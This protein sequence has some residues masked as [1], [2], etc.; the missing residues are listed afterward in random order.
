MGIEFF[1]AIFE[2]SLILTEKF[3]FLSIDFFGKIFVSSSNV[4]EVIREFL[5]FLFLIFLRKDFTR[6][7]SI[8]KHKD[9]AKQ[10]HKKKKHKDAT[11]QKRKRRKKHKSANKRI[12]D[13]FP[14]RCFLS[15]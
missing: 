8:K 6:T 10:K 4:N 7:K 2:T 1:F 12:S 9:A 5:N 11:G 13:F 14:P 15:A 3:M